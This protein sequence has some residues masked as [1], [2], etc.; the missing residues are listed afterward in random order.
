MGY[1]KESPAY[2]VYYP[3]ANRISKVRC[4]K[5]IDRSENEINRNHDQEDEPLPNT[6][7]I[8]NEV[9]ND[10]QL[11]ESVSVAENEGNNRYP[12]RTRNRPQYFDGCALGHDFHNDNANCAIDYCYRVGDIPTC[13]NEAVNST[14]SRK[15]QRAMKDEMEALE[16]NATYDLVPPPEG[17]QIVGGI[18]LRSKN[19]TQWRRNP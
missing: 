16:D 18:G 10:V 3:E 12:T 2:L 1:D 11:D 9:T 4:V 19:W 8:T 7:I 6:K 17:R 15:W 14:E 13:Y 5:F